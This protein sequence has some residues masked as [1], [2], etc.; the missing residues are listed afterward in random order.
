M[1]RDLLRRRRDVSDAAAAHYGRFV[2]TGDVVLDIGANVGNRTAT[3]I[4]LGAR[5]IAVE[6]QPSCAARLRERFGEAVTVVEAVAGPTVG[7]AELL[8]ADYHTLATLSREWIDEVKAS[9][10]FEEFTWRGRLRV[11]MTTLDELIATYGSPSFCKIDVEG[12]EL[13]VIEGLSMPVP[14][15]SFEFTFELLDSRVACVDRLSALGM[16]R[17]NF[18]VGESMRLSRKRWVS[19]DEMRE[20]LRS[21]PRDAGFFGDVYAA[22]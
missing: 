15:L 10:R 13:G 9:G 4:E 2:E 19:A 6:P 5:V 14:A 22:R 8:V 7:E 12:Y 3:F 11:P 20:F 17:F 21:T 18:S 1:L 16:T